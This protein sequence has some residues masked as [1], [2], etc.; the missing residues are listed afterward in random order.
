MAAEEARKARIYLPSCE[1]TIDLKVNGTI[2]EVLTWERN[3]LKEMQ[4]AAGFEA[5]AGGWMQNEPASLSCSLGNFTD[6]FKKGEAAIKLQLRATSAAGDGSP[7]VSSAAGRRRRNGVT[8]A[9]APV[10]SASPSK[11]KKL[12]A[13]VASIPS[14][15]VGRFAPEASNCDTNGSGR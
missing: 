7:A 5:V 9:E 14:A 6:G 13:S 12:A 3:K 1:K 2:R 11:P 10:A 15:V 4:M 8:S